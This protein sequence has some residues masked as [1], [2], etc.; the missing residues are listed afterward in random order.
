M[1]YERDSIFQ[2]EEVKR[3]LMVLKNTKLKELIVTK[4][5]SRSE[6]QRCCLENWK[7]TLWE[8]TENK[9]VSESFKCKNSNFWGMDILN[10]VMRCSHLNLLFFF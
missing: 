3:R 9:N 5:V 1:R 6:Y 8:L 7:K 4:T 2:I 10:N